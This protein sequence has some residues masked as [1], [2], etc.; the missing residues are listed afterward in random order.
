M[1]SIPSFPT[2]HFDFGAIKEL[3]P[4]L[5]KRGIDRPLIITDQGLVEHGVYQKL[6]DALPRNMA[7][8]AFDKIPENPTITGVE[9]ALEIYRANNCNGIIGL[10]GGSVL[11]SG[12]A[13]R[14]AA[15]HHKS[16]LDILNNLDKITANVA[17]YIT[18]PTTAGTG[19]EITFGGGIHPETNSPALTIRSIHVQPDLAICD[20]EF[21]MTLPP[22]LTAATG[23]DALTHCVEGFLSNISNPPTEAI[24]LDGTRR[25]MDFIERAVA[26]GSDREARSQ[27]S[28]AALQGGMAIYM[29]LGPIHALSMAFGDSPL[30]HGTLVTVAMPAVMRF[31]NGK[32]TGS[33]LEK[34]AEAMHLTGDKEAGNRIA[35]AVSEMNGKLGLPSTVRGMGYEKT[36]I[37]RMVRECC[38]SGFNIPAPIRP[39]SDEYEKLVVEVLG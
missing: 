25:V 15:T 21:T 27:M 3:T 33:G 36:D 23:M 34:Y 35:D 26:D 39:T 18:I 20:P 28:M 10:G 24:A 11:D 22:R 5:A 31:Y 12:K 32:I 8:S 13:L 4:E 38:N 7:V 19:A 37:D 17:P 14:V 30:H 29:G 1:A 2:I 6:R 16:V 9:Q